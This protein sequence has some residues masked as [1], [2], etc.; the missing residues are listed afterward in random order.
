MWGSGSGI[1]ASTAKINPRGVNEREPV[2]CGGGVYMEGV[3]A[4]GNPM[5]GYVDAY[6]YYHYK[7]YYDCDSWVYDR[8]YVKLR[9]VSLRYEFPKKFVNSLGIG[10]TRASIAFVANNPWLIYSAVPNIDP[11]EVVGTSYYY[12]EGG[13]A[14]STR[15]FGATINL[16]F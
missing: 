15:T 13:Q 8:T 16:T 6:Q 3:D 4:N 1:L 5:S 2:P 11:S 12:L 7:A 10:L 14:M 9:E